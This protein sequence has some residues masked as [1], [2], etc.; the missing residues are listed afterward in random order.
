MNQTGLGCRTET[1]LGCRTGRRLAACLVTGG[2]PEAATI[3]PLD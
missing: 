1:G 2:V 3:G